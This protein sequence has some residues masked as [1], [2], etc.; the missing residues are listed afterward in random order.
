MLVTGTFQN[1][2]TESV[3]LCYGREPELSRLRQSLVPGTSQESFQTACLYGMR[4]VGKTHPALEYACNHIDDYE[5][6]LW[7]AVETSLKLQ[8]SFANIAH[9]MGLSDD[10]VQHPDQ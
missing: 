3:Q 4:G 8:Q 9:G 1:L 10:S 7:V 5:I 2:P 6:I